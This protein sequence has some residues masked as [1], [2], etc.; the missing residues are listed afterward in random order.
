[1]HRQ[2]IAEL[3]SKAAAPADYAQWR[4]Q[5][6]SERLAGPAAAGIWNHLI[7][8]V[9]IGGRSGDAAA[10]TVSLASLREQ[11]YRNIE[12][13]VLGPQDSVPMDSADFYGFRGLAAEPHLTPEMLLAEE[14]CDALWRGDYLVFADAGT[15]FDP[16]AF[17]LLNAALT[18]GRGSLRPD[19]VLCDHDRR[20]GSGDYAAPSFLPGWDADLIQA[21][22]YVGTAFMVSRRLVHSQRSAGR[23]GSLHE[24][25]RRLGR[26]QPGPATAHVAETAMH[27]AG[28]PPAPPAPFVPSRLPAGRPAAAIVIP[29][30]NHPELLARC[31]GFLDYANHFRPEIVVV[32]NASDDPALPALYAELKE[33][34]GIQVLTW[35]SRSISRA[36]SILASPRPEPS[37]WCF[38][39]TMSGF[40]RLARSSSCSPGP[41]ARKW[42][43]S[44]A[45]FSTPTARHSMPGCFCA[46]ARMALRGSGPPMCIAARR[47]RRR[48]ICIS[49]RPRGIGRR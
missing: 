2:P 20:L 8:L 34:Y 28:P 42:A 37:W 16:D 31:L 12:L 19:L 49:S 18:P 25:L 41:C 24:W 36:W 23:A 9:L 39:T 27:L 5:R 33:R 29:N 26:S 11:R 45:V 14:A 46:Q 6:L 7:T 40:P 32:D 21:F 17:A 4:R 44:A 30:R 1:M 10:L 43:S 48:V 47:G 15:E 3:P 35:T 22:D 13:L 38:S